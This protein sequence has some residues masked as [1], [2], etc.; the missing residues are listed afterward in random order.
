M[1]KLKYLKELHNDFVDNINC[2]NDKLQNDMKKIKKEYQ[3]NVINEK[4]KLL[5]AI[6]NGE[7]LD[8]EKIK[9]KYLTSKELNHNVTEYA[10]PENKITEENLLDKIEIN[11]EEYY[12]EQKE[13]GSIYNMESE[14]VGV[15]KD[16]KFIFN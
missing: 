1:K 15:Y 2:L 13:K 9:S 11:G 16:G 7:G 3:Q 4:I 6:C 10:V 8:V 12:Y 14:I 5:M